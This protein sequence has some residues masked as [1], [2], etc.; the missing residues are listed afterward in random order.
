APLLSFLA[1]QT[2]AAIVLPADKQTQPMT[3]FVG[4]GPFRF[5]E[6]APDRYVRL[7]RFD[8][9]VPRPEPPDNYGG[10]RT[11]YV[12]EL[13][14]V[15]VPNA[16]TRVSGA[17]AGQYDYGDSLPVDALGRLR[18]GS[19]EPVVFK[20][21]GWPLMFV[22]HK[23]GPLTNPALR[24]A[25]AAS[26]SFE[27]ML[28]AAF[29]EPE[30]YALDPAF[31][32]EGFALHSDAGADIYRAAGDP[33]R[34][35][36]M[37]E[38][39]GYKGEKIRIMVSQQYDFHFKLAT[40]AAEYMRQADLNAELAVVD[41]ATLLQ[42]RNEAGAWEIFITHGPIL[43]EPTLYSFMSPAAPGWWSGPGRDAAVAAFDGEANPQRRA[44]LWGPVQQRIYE[45]V[46][47]IR[48]GNFG[49]LAVR[50]RRLQGLTPAVW[51]FFWNT[52]IES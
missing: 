25:V 12:D 43:P 5:V 10:G 23:Q 2:S 6:R 1:L 30:F 7:Q 41:W 19:V 13:R 28:A 15:P 52:W 45:D 26:L 50:S 3:E 47:V 16:A 37:A 8:G 39:A 17:L 18:S 46:P 14:F 34:A 24:R 31:Y 36:A 20:S 29:G 40:V 9:Y 11:P 22:N 49:A 4:T 51:P 38:Q 21:F 32:P 27:D 48:A 33:A 44:A 42:S 35:K